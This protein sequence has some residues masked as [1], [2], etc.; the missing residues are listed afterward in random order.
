MT[1]TE[2]FRKEVDMDA[3]EQVSREFLGW[4]NDR[5]VLLWS[6]MALAESIFLTIDQQ[7]VTT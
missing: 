2:L 3:Y 5:C 4:Y 1:D 6:H 7:Q